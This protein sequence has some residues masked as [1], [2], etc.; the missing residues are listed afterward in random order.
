MPPTL[1]ELRRAAARL[2]SRGKHRPG[3]QDDYATVPVTVRARTSDNADMR[4]L[5]DVRVEAGTLQADD[6]DRF[7][8]ECAVP[9]TRR[10][11]AQHDLAGLQADL[12]PELG[13]VAASVRDGLAEVGATL[14]DVELVAAEHLLSSP[15]ADPA[16]G[17]E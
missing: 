11:V 7:V 14:L 8:H 4:L 6:L 10:W 1:A 16:D 12:A 13:D 5:L 17:P 9:A 2:V 15:S 3:G